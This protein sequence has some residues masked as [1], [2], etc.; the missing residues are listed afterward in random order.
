MIETK[1]LILR[2]MTPED[3][4]DLLLVFS[5]PE[6]MASF[7]GQLFDHAQMTRWVQCNL[8]HQE[9]HGYGLFS[10]LLKDDAQLIGDC[11][12]EHMDV[13]GSPE[14]ELGYDL[15]SDYWGRGLATEAAGAVRD[16][17]WQHLPLRRLISLIRPA[18]VASRRV[19]EKIGMAKESEIVRG[20]S[21]YWIYALARD[22]TPQ[23][24]M[25]G[26]EQS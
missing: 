16:F 11:G 24:F 8:K 10:V 12:L 13:A 15:R 9:T 22:A 26:S 3:T 7:G 19:A 23:T 1:R 20:E 2:P 4:D 25:N 17:A 21:T 14:I 6:V 5:D 18:N